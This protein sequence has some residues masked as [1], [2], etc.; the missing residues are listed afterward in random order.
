[1]KKFQVRRSTSLLLILAMLTACVP[2]TAWLNQ[3]SAEAGSSSEPLLIPVSEDTY[4]QGG[5]SSNNNYGGSTTLKLK[6]TSSE[7]RDMFLK[8]NLPTIDGFVEE[9]V[10]QLFVKGIESATLSS[11][12]KGYNID[13]RGIDDDSWTEMGLTYSNAPTEQG[14]VLDTVF[15]GESQ[16]GSYVSLD[17][18]SFVKA[19]QD[20]TITLR[21]RGVDSSRGADYASRE[22]AATGKPAQ[23][24]LAIGEKQVLTE[25][26]ELSAESGHERVELAWTEVAGALG[27]T[28]KRASSPEGPYETL[29]AQTTALLYVDEP[30]VNGETYYYKVS[31]YNEAGPGPDSDMATGAPIFPL[32]VSITGIKDMKGQAVAQLDD[33]RFAIIEAEASNVGV[34][35][36]EARIVFRLL[37]A[38][39]TSVAKVTTVKRLASQEQTA[40]KAGFQLPADAAGY[41]VDVQIELVEEGAIR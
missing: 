34:E 21:L 22:D 26:P 41:E 11:P 5:T 18:T 12:E 4:V 17:V 13:V 14:L 30:V 6:R 16:I 40:L 10:L 15:V 3:A 28:V 9:A 27:Y 37:D 19:H 33:T 29:A 24:V 1:M 2:F 7:N 32:Q 38:S 23:L 31:A 8:F 35:S 20:A 25:A 36:A 39:G